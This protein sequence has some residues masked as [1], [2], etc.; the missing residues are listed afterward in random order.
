[1]SRFF[2]DTEF[3]EDGTTI[4]LLSIALVHDSG[5]SLYLVSSEVDFCEAGAWVKTNVLPSIMDGANGMH[6][7]AEI[8]DN[9]LSFVDKHRS[10]E[11][12]KFWGYYADY[13][14]VA[15]CQLFGKMIDLPKGWPMY[16]RDLKQ[17]CDELGNPRLP[18]NEAHHALADARWIKAQYDHLME[19]QYMHMTRNADLTV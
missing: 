11:K 8:K 19:V 17:L 16:C 10:G 18:K 15:F 13:D 14:W 6:T 12:P 9:I 1:M 3:I 4:D 2:L 5:Q 7:R